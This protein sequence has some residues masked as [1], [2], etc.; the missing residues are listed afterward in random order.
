MKEIW[1]PIKGFETYLIS[2]KGNILNTLTNKR[3]QPS[4]NEK[5]YLR[6]FLV[7]NKKNYTKYVHRLVAEHFIPNPDNKPTVNHED[8]CKSNN[9]VSNLSWATYKEQIEHSLRTGLTKTGV[10]HPLYGKSLPAEIREKMKIK[11]N[12]NKEKFNKPINQYDLNGNFIKTWESINEA[13]RFYNNKA[14]EFC[15]KGKRKSA[16]GYQWKFY[17]NDTD[18]ISSKKQSINERHILQYDL[19]GNF[20]KEYS[21]IQDACNEVGAF[22]SNISMCC[23]GKSKTCKGYIWKYKEEI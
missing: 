16:S 20:I 6:T 5:G 13:I 18:N 4:P 11:R 1:K 14:I 3:K 21:K 23:S 9:V 12:L 19:N 8:G 22:N 17:I 15:C 10:N 2:N 7:K